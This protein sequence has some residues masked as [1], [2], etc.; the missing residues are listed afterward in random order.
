MI[1]KRSAAQDPSEILATG[2]AALEQLL[3][4]G[5]K[6]TQLTNER[7]S[8]PSAVFD[9]RVQITPPDSSPYTELL[10]EVPNKPLS[11]RDVLNKTV[12]M[13]TVL[14]QAQSRVALLVIAPWLSPRTQEVLREHD[15]AYLDLTGNVSL[16]I[17][18]PAIRFHTQG[19]SRAPSKESSTRNVTLAGPRAG[20]IVRFLA[21]YLPP[22]R[23]S[24]IVTQANVSAP[25]VSRLLGQ[26]EDQLLIQREGR[27]IVEVRWPELLRARAD[28]Y[29]LLRPGN[30]EQMVAPSGA[31]AV[32]DRLRN[33]PPPL[34]G[35]SN[36]AVTGSYAARTIAPRTVGGQ[37][38]LYVDHLPHSIDEWQE[39]LGLIRVDEHADVLLLRAPDT[40]VFDRYRIVDGVAQVGYSQ[41]VLDCLAGT[42]RMP[43]EG[44]TILAV[45]ADDESW[46]LRLN[47]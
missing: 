25:W 32:L 24:E 47:R 13:I 29:T 5:W 41:L 43:A 36:I 42:G 26:L 28:A 39:Q 46:R 20:R 16:A 18:Y 22:Y 37:L 9:A 10:V 12:P 4:H 11:P 3:G 2:L 38:M 23:A 1:E 21:D 14:R 31:V 44:E 40:A 15:I 33:V 6:V 17:T 34:S 35:N 45:L 8:L 7:S 27:D 30:H 19:A